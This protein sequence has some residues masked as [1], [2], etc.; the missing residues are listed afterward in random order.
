MTAADTIATRKSG[1]P[2]KTTNKPIHTMTPKGANSQKKWKL[3]M[4]EKLR[5]HQLKV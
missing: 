5:M 3:K 4:E 1:R 2:W